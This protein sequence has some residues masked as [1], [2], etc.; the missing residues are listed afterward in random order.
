MTSKPITL[1]RAA[2]VLLHPSSLPGPHGIGDIGKISHD[3]VDWLHSAGIKVWQ[4]L[5]LGPTG[6]GDSPYASPASMAGNPW[7]VGLELLDRG[8]PRTDYAVLQGT[9]VVGKVTSGTHSPT[10]KKPIALAFVRPDLAVVGTEL[11]IDIRGQA[12]KA[13]V[14]PYPFVTPGSAKA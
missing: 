9:E 10:A 8:V 13:V 7:L 11:A 5:P 1:P 3:F 12:K 6:G 4:V 14:V 2:G